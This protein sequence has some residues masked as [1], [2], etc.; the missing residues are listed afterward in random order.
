M[1]QVLLNFSS[2]T[3]EISRFAKPLKFFFSP[4]PP[5][6][7]YF[8]FVRAVCTA[9]VQRSEDSLWKSFLFFNHVFWR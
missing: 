4:S 9:R 3:S 1:P 5:P 2:T 6:P 7:S 8:V